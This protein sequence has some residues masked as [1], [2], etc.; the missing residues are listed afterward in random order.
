M[1]EPP[2][3]VIQ[4]QLEVTLNRPLRVRSFVVAPNVV[5]AP[6]ER[7]EFLSA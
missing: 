7:L 1:L 4:A 2:A 6:V 3:V 5:I